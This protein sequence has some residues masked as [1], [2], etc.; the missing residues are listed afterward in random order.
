MGN[1]MFQVNR[2]VD[3]HAIRFFLRKYAFFANK[4]LLEVSEKLIFWCALMRDSK[5]LPAGETPASP[6]SSFWYQVSGIVTLNQT[7]LKLVYPD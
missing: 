2:A 3:Q 7:N 1:Q 5:V 4:S 6:V